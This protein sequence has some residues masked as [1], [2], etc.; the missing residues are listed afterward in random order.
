M[1]AK[2][3]KLPNFRQQ[4][5][6]R[7]QKR[8]NSQFRTESINVKD[9][10][11]AGNKSPDPTKMNSDTVIT[12]SPQSKRSEVEINLTREKSGSL[13]DVIN[14]GLSSSK[15]QPDSDCL[16]SLPSKSATIQHHDRVVP[17]ADEDMVNNI[18][19]TSTKMTPS[20]HELLQPSTTVH[21]T[22]KA[23]DTELPDSSPTIADELS[24]STDQIG[25]KASSVRDEINDKTSMSSPR[26]N[27]NYAEIKAENNTSDIR[28]QSESN[29]TATHVPT[30]TPKYQHFKEENVN[31]NSERQVDNE[32]TLLK[33]TLDSGI[34]SEIATGMCR[35]IWLSQ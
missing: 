2:Y 31:G 18:S 3:G 11:H 29:A 5:K 17:A 1:S 28:L 16:S 26:M 34:G 7:T 4:E 21:D 22:F 20:L 33:G 32:N 12:V 9:V 35:V 14:S 25:A 13:Y 10:D 23:S 15:L 8:A 6:K 19:V 27:I 30:E 24:Q